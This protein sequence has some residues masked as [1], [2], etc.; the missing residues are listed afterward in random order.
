MTTSIKQQAINL[1]DG[2]EVFSGP[3]FETDE[4]FNVVLDQSEEYIKGASAQVLRE[5]NRLINR[6]YRLN[7]QRKFK[8]DTTSICILEGAIL[9]AL[10]AA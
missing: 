7:D 9:D 10:E 3:L 4:G 8:R 1:I 5:A 6:I 2:F